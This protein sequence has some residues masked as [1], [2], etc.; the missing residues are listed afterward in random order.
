MNSS[1]WSCKKSLIPGASHTID[2]Q[3]AWLSSPAHQ[4]RTEG[5]NI[6]LDRMH[7]ALPN[8]QGGRTRPPGS[9]FRPRTTPRLVAIVGWRPRQHG[10]L[11]AVVCL[12]ILALVIVF[13][14]NGSAPLKDL[15][16]G[17]PETVIVTVLNQKTMSASFMALIKKNRE[18]Y[19]E[20]HSKTQ[21]HLH[22]GAYSYCSRLRSFHA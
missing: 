4:H 3:V 12:L 2:F 9:N 7:Y 15:P 17:V 22:P 13:R 16:L 18:T 8:R 1:V 14:S 10:R 20:A 5:V 6:H 19:A 21:C 11:L